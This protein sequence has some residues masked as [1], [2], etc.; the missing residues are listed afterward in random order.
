MTSR[1]TD[2]NQHIH[3]LPNLR[4]M[5]AAP[6]TWR[7]PRATSAPMIVSP[8]WR[9]LADELRAC[10]GRPAGGRLQDCVLLSPPYTGS[11]TMRTTLHSL[12]RLPEQRH[13]ETLATARSKNQSQRCFLVTLRDPID[14][15]ESGVRYR[16]RESGLAN[17]MSADSL[18]EAWQ[19]STHPMH[20]FAARVAF[21]PSLLHQAEYIAGHRCDQTT[22]HV[23]C[24]RRLSEDLE[25]LFA[26]YAVSHPVRSG[27]RWSMSVG[28]TEAVSRGLTPLRSSSGREFVRR[29]AGFDDYL[30]RTMCGDS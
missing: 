8:R 11:T 9:E 21:G 14:R 15:L 19:N 29:I 20:A 2:S 25:R 30:H 5:R 27:G 28:G 26:L 18:V 22:V 7:T 24:T 6:A 17:P 13:R 10:P 3:S 23:L 16:A 12:A 1:K 4:Y